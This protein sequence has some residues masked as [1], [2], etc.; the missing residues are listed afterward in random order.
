MSLKISI[1]GIR[2]VIGDGLDAESV[3]RFASAFGSWLPEGS[4][5]VG[6]DSRPS[7]PMLHASVIGALL[8]TGHD[9]VDAGILSTPGTE[10]LVQTTDAVGGVIITASHN[11]V[12][13]NALKL[14]ESNGLFLDA[15]Q[16]QAVIDLSEMGERRH[17]RALETGTVET[18]DDAEQR[19]LAAILACPLVD[20]DAVR[21]ARLKVVVDAVEGAGGRALPSLLRQMGVECIALYCD[22]TGLFPHDPEPRPDHLEELR[23][24]V[25]TEDADLGLAVDPDVDRL[26]LIDRGG[27]ALSEEVTLA[28]AVDHVLEREK[29]PVV[30]NLS[31][32]LVVAAVAE[33]HGV[34]LLR[35]PVGEVNV[36]ARMLSE[37]A[38]VGGEGNGGVILP[39]LHPGRDA[40]LGAA[41][42][43]SAVASRGS[44]RNCLE[45]LPDAAM[46]KSKLV[47]TPEL[48][49]PARW[50]TALTAL[51]DGGV[52]DRQDGLKYDLGDRWIHL[53]RS[54]TE[55]AVRIIAE[56]SKQDAAR[57][58]VER[59]R[60]LLGTE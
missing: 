28:V 23:L 57:D 43:L 7:G 24:R 44:L 14:L 56:A 42:V 10:Y 17:V 37:K 55:N 38:I 48:D 19:H 39:S 13:W 16:M 59:V 3:G 5:V 31:T 1:S 32:S 22:R 60:R 41:L 25:E 35:T 27:I 47:L 20:V 11:P 4:V 51:V 18:V 12:E 21:A 15:S 6:R 2:G 29:G 33:R 40:L 52:M 30:I 8:S 36:V 26:A 49:D 53:R 9:V 50:E 45:R 58:L 54:N 34:P 46:H